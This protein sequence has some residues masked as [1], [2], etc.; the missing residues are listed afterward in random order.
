MK[1]A[2][3]TSAQVIEKK[4]SARPREKPPTAGTRLPMSNEGRF[5]TCNKDPAG[6]IEHCTNTLQ[7]KGKCILHAT[8]EPPLLSHS[9]EIICNIEHRP[10]LEKAT[11]LLGFS[12]TI[13]HPSRQ[14]TNTLEL[15]VANRWQ[16]GASLPPKLRH[17]CSGVPF[18]ANTYIR[19]GT[20]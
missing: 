9:H 2:S 18:C 14:R 12:C 19:N 16:G 1:P 15:T 4:S 3:R 13:A 20:S 11:H 7:G 5:A 6:T 17:G 10:G 8:Q